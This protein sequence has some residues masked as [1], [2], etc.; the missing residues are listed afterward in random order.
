MANATSV[1]LNRIGWCFFLNPYT[2]KL[3]PEQPQ[4]ERVLVSESTQ[5]VANA[6][7]LCSAQWRKRRIT[8]VGGR[9]MLWLVYFLVLAGREKPSGHHLSKPRRLASSSL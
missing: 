2:K 5:T 6:L 3:A 8:W 4:Q 7:V 9:R 1:C